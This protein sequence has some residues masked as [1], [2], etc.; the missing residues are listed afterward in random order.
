VAVAGKL[1]PNPPLS[2][3]RRSLFGSEGFFYWRD[4]LTP[5]AS[6]SWRNE[7]STFATTYWTGWTLIRVFGFRV[8]LIQ[9]GPW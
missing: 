6:R 1:Y 7:R 8:A 2:A 9:K 4:A 5:V 3:L